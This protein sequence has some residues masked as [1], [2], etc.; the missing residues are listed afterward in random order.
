MLPSASR[1]CIVADAGRENA[2]LNWRRAFRK[3]Y[4]AVFQSVFFNETR[5]FG[6]LSDF[7]NLARPLGHILSL[8]P[9]GFYPSLTQTI[10]GDKHSRPSIVRPAPQPA[11]RRL[12]SAAVH[13]PPPCSPYRQ[14]DDD[15]I[16]RDRDR[17]EQSG[18]HR[19]R[20]GRRPERDACPPGAT[21]VAEP[22]EPPATER[23][24]IGSG[25]GRDRPQGASTASEAAAI[26]AAA[27]H[28]P[29]SGGPS[30]AGRNRTAAWATTPDGSHSS[31]SVQNPSP[32]KSPRSSIR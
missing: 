13:Q 11:R 31:A 16:E 25:A 22:P 10:D 29:W 28:M 12:P 8:S 20:Y 5:Q 14:A 1:S 3:K 7:F 15:R 27:S 17:A 23:P 26:G 6:K 2:P 18:H 32:L 9:I 21:P 24:R 19:H 30:V 4:A